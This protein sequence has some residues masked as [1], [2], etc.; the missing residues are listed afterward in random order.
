MALCPTVIARPLPHCHCEAEGRGNLDDH[1]ARRSSLRLRP[2]RP[3]PSHARL[4]RCARNDR[5]RMALCPTVIARPLLYCHCETPT[6]LSL[7]DPYPTVI[8]RPLPH[9][10]CEAEGRGN[11]DDH[12]A[13]R[14]SLRLRPQRPFPSHARLPRCARNDRGRMALCPTV[15]A[16]PLLYCHCETPTPLSLRDP[17]PTVIARPLPHCH[18]EAEGRGNLDDHNARRSAPG[19]NGR[20]RPTRDCRAALAMTE[21][22][23]LFALL[24]LRDPYP[25]VIAR[26]LPHCHCATPTPL[27]LRGRRPWQSRRPQRA[28]LRPR[29]QR[30]FP[31]HARLPRCARND[32]GRMA[33]CPTVIARPLPHCHC[34]AEGRGNPDDHNARRAAP[35]PNGR[36]RPTRDCRAALA[37]TEGGWRFALLSL[38]DPYPT[39]IA[40]PLPHCHCEAEGRGNP[41][42]HNAR[43]SSLRLRPQRPFPSHRDCRV[44][45][46]PRNDS[47]GSASRD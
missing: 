13:R 24:S 4:P 46:A 31:S 2:Q 11:L 34:E 5:G 39:V 21:G 18:C 29:L 33:L 38:R 30:P 15:I 16:R 42:D 17:Y 27:S 1:N 25:T 43:R 10:H 45:G 40:R 28:A 20:S 6:P 3:F 23:W 32:R 37:M 47:R 22:G 19:S 36:S 12:N 8:A 35:G 14:S 44:A 9:C 41:D 26:P 7:R